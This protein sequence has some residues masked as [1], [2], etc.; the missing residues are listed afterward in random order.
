M[1]GISRKTG[2]TSLQLGIITPST[3][4]DLACFKCDRNNTHTRV[5]NI[6]HLIIKT[7]IIAH[8]PYLD[9]FGNDT[10]SSAAVRFRNVSTSQ[11]LFAE[12][13]RLGLGIKISASCLCSAVV[14]RHPVESYTY[15]RTWKLQVSDVISFSS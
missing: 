14:T 4:P 8:V 7:F 10:R 1:L 9:E 13:A 11:S 3:L 15:F 12:V 5:L 2:L 6:I